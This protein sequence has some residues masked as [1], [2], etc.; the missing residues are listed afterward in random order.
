[1]FLSKESQQRILGLGQTKL[2]LVFWGYCIAGTLI[3]GF[4]SFR[5]F[6]L[7]PSHHRT[8]GN[9]VTGVLFVAYFLW[10]HV[11]LWKCAFNVKQRGWGYAA[12]CCAV[13]VVIF[14]FVG[15]AANFGA[16]SGTIG[17]RKVVFPPAQAVSH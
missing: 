4:L 3:V 9:L 8:L 6:R 11:L 10:A 12:R 17:I 5:A 13:V 2:T 16:G 14:Y 7:F 15:V 1:M